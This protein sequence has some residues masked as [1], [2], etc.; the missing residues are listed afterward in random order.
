MPF[1]ERHI[2]SRSRSIP[3]QDVQ[4]E[5]YQLS[6]RL[7]VKTNEEKLDLPEAVVAAWHNQRA[8]SVEVNLR[9]QENCCFYG[10]Y[11][12]R[13]ARCKVK[14]LTY[15]RDGVRMSWQS[16]QT[17]PSL[18]VPNPHTFIELEATGRK[19]QLLCSGPA[20]ILKES[21]RHSPIPTRWGWTAGWSC[22]RRRSCCDLSGFSSTFPGFKKRFLCLHLHRFRNRIWF[23]T[24]IF[25]FSGL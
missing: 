3:G 7:S 11:S 4:L 1:L 12:R 22:S 14:C 15:G 5:C 20:L 23:W 16:F 21:C 17:L 6:T 19:D 13:C 24:W 9:Y 10:D 25:F 8:V 2:S 18:Y